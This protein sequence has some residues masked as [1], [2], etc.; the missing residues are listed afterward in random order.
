MSQ[1]LD[2]LTQYSS[3]SDKWLPN[4]WDIMWKQI[5]AANNVHVYDERKK[6]VN[7]F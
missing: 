1:K 6:I 5:M 4:P 3:D 7:L 2:S